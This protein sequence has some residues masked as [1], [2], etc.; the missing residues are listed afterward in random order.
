LTELWQGHRAKKRRGIHDALLKN[1][2]ENGW[3]LQRQWPKNA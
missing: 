3:S 2:R 1:G